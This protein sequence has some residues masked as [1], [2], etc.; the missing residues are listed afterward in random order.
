MILNN[1]RSQQEAERQ[2]VSAIIERDRID[3]IREQDRAAAEIEVAEGVFVNLS[4]SVTE[5]TPEWISK[6]DVRTFVPKQPD[7][8]ARVI[9]TV[10]RDHSSVVK[11][12]LIAGRLGE[13]HFHAAVWYQRMHDIAG[14]NGRASASQWSTVGVVSR[15]PSD[16]GFGY[17]PSSQMIAEARDLYRGARAVVPAG[18]VRFFEAVAVSNIPIRRATRFA[19]CRNE[20]AAT[21]FRDCAELVWQF[22]D[23]CGLDF[24]KYDDGD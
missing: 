11:R 3:R 17:V 24:G 2:R 16:A 12:M 18:Y 8:T 21:R 9:T 5:P 14:M 22:C 4:D 20:L 7:N 13:E 6:G 10:R 15:S 19:R 1:A 23:S